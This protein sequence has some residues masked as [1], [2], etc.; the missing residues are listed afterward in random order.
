MTRRIVNPVCHDY[1]PCIRVRRGLRQL[2]SLT[3]GSI[4]EVASLLRLHRLAPA[5]TL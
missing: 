2:L 3:L 1:R 5:L 4:C